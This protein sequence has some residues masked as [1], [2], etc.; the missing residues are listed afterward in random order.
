MIIKEKR[1]EGYTYIYS[2]VDPFTNEI[3]YVGKTVNPRERYKEHLKEKYNT[4]KCNW[5]QSL[6]LK[7]VEPEFM[8][9]DIVKTEEWE[10]W[11]RHYIS[12]YK[13]WGFNLTNH[14]EGGKDPLIVPKYGSENSFNIP[15]VREKIAERSKNMKGKSLEEIYGE[16]K[17]LE[18]KE[19]I[20]LGGKEAREA[21]RIRK[22]YKKGKESPLYGIKKTQE[23]KDKISKA[24]M[25][26]RNGQYGVKKTKEQKEYL[27][28][29]FKGKSKS[30]E[31]KDKISKANKG[32]KQSQETKD[33]VKATR[34]KNKIGFKGTVYQYTLDL[35]LVEKHASL[36]EAAIKIGK[37]EA[38]ISTV[39]NGKAVKA[40][41]FRWSRVPLELE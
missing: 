22:N 41:G 2:L 28:N 31:T 24:N 21:G 16:K 14:T 15:W 35:I 5:V 11:E 33:K 10:F 34:I 30:Q 7:G 19:K 1:I 9:L 20:K 25:G 6:L 37:S 17:A 40:Y 39:L 18:I 12:L 29:L 13:S 3:R 23:T 32:K 4:R 27:S 26:E 38:N 8:V 36:K